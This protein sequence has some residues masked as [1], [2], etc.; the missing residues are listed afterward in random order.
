MAYITKVK[1]G[2]NPKDGE[3]AKR[4]ASIWLI[5]VSNDVSGPQ[6]MHLLI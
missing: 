5:L 1:D 2:F 4:H 6:Q 3:A